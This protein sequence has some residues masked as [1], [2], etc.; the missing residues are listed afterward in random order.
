M[1]IGKTQYSTLTWEEQTGT[2]C[3]TN[4]TPLLSIISALHSTNFKDQLTAKM[5]LSLFYTDY[6]GLYVEEIDPNAYDIWINW[7]NKWL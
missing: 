4:E 6:F 7:C 5:K 1:Y 3:R 2:V